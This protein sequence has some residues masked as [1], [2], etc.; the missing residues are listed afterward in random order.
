MQPEKQHPPERLKT[1]I[2][3]CEHLFVRS[4][5]PPAGPETIFLLSNFFFP[6]TQ[7]L[8][9]LPCRS[10]ETAGLMYRITPA[11]PDTSVSITEVRKEASRAR[12][13]E[14]LLFSLCTIGFAHFLL[15]LAGIFPREIACCQFSSLIPAQHCKNILS[16]P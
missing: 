15:G 3:A 12:E 5:S 6:I 8:G 11:R 13:T 7:S 14:T 10:T 4:C 16:L 9:S 2:T 1:S